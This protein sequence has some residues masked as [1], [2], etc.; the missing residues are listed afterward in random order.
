MVAPSLS[1]ASAVPQGIGAIYHYSL[2][3]ICPLSF[4]VVATRNVNSCKRVNKQNNFMITERLGSRNVIKGLYLWSQLIPLWIDLLRFR[5]HS[6]NQLSCL[7]LVF[8]K[9]IRKFVIFVYSFFGGDVEINTLRSTPHPIKVPSTPNQDQVY[10]IK[11]QRDEIDNLFEP[12]DKYKF[13]N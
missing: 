6:D 11:I 13:Q 4:C 8:L 3:F 1:H 5:T 10:K 12:G 2:T 9:E 7:N